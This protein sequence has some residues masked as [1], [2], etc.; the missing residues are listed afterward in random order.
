M[1][2][3]PNM[4]I[5]LGPEPAIV[6]LTGNVVL[7]NNEMHIK[8]FVRWI[9]CRPGGLSDGFMRRNPDVRLIR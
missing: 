1:P 3:A 5:A 2:I 6:T 9:G 4:I 7:R 8:T